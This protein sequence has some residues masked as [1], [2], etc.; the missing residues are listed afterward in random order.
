MK[1]DTLL[2]FGARQQ[3]GLIP[4]LD[5]SLVLYVVVH[6]LCLFSQIIDI[7]VKKKE[8]TITEKVLSW[9]EKDA[10][11]CSFHFL[12]NFK[13]C[14]F[15]SN[16]LRQVSNRVGLKLTFITEIELKIKVFFSCACRR[17]MF[18]ENRKLP[19]LLSCTFWCLL[20]HNCLKKQISELPKD[21]NLARFF[22]Q[23]LAMNDLC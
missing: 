13:C 16:V 18:Q 6:T 14:Y 15:V 23:I 3:G 11:I 19:W 20:F 22:K 21:I 9:E 7:E 10:I 4:Y 1:S 12:L 2:Q 5:I 8:Y 17:Q